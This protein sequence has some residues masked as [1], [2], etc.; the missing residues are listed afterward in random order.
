MRWLPRRCRG[1]DQGS[2]TPRTK[3]VRSVL[4]PVFGTLAVHKSRANDRR[5]RCEQTDLDLTETLTA[6]LDSSG[7]PLVGSISGQMDC[8]S[9]MSGMPDLSLSFTDPSILGDA[10]AAF[11]SCV[12]YHRWRKEKLVSFVPRKC[13]KSLFRKPQR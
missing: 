7:K 11:H 13:W 9:R 4:L 5:T 6:L 1:E 10:G 2:N 8:R 3:S 12:R